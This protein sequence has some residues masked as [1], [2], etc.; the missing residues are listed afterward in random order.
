MKKANCVKNKHDDLIAL[1]FSETDVTI[2]INDSGKYNM[3]C[4]YRRIWFAWPY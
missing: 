2:V 1:E 3:T 4:L